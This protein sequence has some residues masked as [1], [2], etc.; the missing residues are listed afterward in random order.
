[1]RPTHHPHFFCAREQAKTATISRVVHGAAALQSIFRQT[2]HFDILPRR[3][4]AN[5]DAG[6]WNQLTAEKTLSAMQDA[7][8]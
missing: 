7:Q 8:R 6:G 2:A 1:M 3:M 5:C 4:P